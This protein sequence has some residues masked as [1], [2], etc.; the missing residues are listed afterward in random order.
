MKKKIITGLSS[1]L[2]FTLLLGCFGTSYAWQLPKSNIEPGPFITKYGSSMTTS[3]KNTFTNNF[4]QFLNETNFDTY[5]IAIS[6]QGSKVDQSYIMGFNKSDIN[7]EIRNVNN[8]NYMSVPLNSNSGQRCGLQNSYRVSNISNISAGLSGSQFRGHYLFWSNDLS[9]TVTGPH[10]TETILGPF[11]EPNYFTFT[12]PANSVGYQVNGLSETYYTVTSGYQTYLGS[13]YDSAYVGKIDYQL[14]S[15]NGNSY[16]FSTYKNVY[17]YNKNGY[18]PTWASGTTTRDNNGRYT[19]YFYLDLLNQN[20]NVVVLRISPLLSDL[21]TLYM[22]FYCFD[23]HTHVISGIIYPTNT[24]SGD[25]I[26]QYNQQEQINTITSQSNQNTQDLQDTITDDS[27]VDSMLEETLSGDKI[28]NDIGF[29]FIVNPFEDIIKNT[30][31]GF[32]NALLGSGN[33]TINFS[34][35]NHNYAIHSEDFTLP[36]GALKSFISLLCNAFVVYNICKYG[37]KLYE[38]INTGRIQNLVNEQNR[39]QYYLF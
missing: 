8:L 7:G 2:L 22:Y 6:G 16:S 30:L 18:F 33:E 25:Y 26:Q 28:I 38:W 19:T 36:N 32:T 9:S 10:E 24:F 39:H 4:N 20:N 29:N 14:G 23:G 13:I 31:I 17:N 5:F 3:E 1:I 15:W 21:N 11:Q 34:I 37:F 35:Y 27:K 12:Y